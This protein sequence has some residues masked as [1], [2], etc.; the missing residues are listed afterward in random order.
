MSQTE[1]A[2]RI[3]VGQSTISNFENGKNK[4]AHPTTMERIC[5]LVSKWE[6]EDNIIPFEGDSN[7]SRPMDRQSI[8]KDSSYPSPQKSRHQQENIAS[9]I[10]CLVARLTDGYDQNELE[11][12]LRRYSTT[13][14]L[15]LFD[16]TE[17]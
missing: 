13:H 11:A 12:R 16:I 9:V 6:R 2:G 10:E 14:L 1:I 5:G 3:G 15:D 8:P 4:K 17:E 7:G